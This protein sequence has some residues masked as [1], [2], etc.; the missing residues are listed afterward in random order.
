MTKIQKARTRTKQSETGTETHT[1]T[2]RGTSWE[3]CVYKLIWDLHLLFSIDNVLLRWYCMAGKVENKKLEE[4]ENENYYLL[5]ACFG[6]QTSCTF[7]TDNSLGL[8]G[9][10]NSVSRTDNFVIVNVFNS[11]TSSRV[12]GNRN[13]ARKEELIYETIAAL[14]SNTTC[15][16]P[17]ILGD[18]TCT[19]LWRQNTIPLMNRDHLVGNRYFVPYF[20]SHAVSDMFF[21]YLFSS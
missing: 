13:F 17:A 3:S 20:P 15:L 19:D 6:D 10:D 4:Y 2:R 18:S 7:L 1:R 5:W 12:T 8:S 9:E 16:I 21:P 14:T 11:V